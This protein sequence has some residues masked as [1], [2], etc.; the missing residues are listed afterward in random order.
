MSD[1]CQSLTGSNGSPSLAFGIE[2]EKLNTQPP[3][4]VISL[5]KADLSP[6]V[7]ASIAKSSPE[8]RHSVSSASSTESTASGPPEAVV[9]ADDA[10]PTVAAKAESQSS[11][12]RRAR[13]LSR[14]PDILDLSPDGFTVDSILEEYNNAGVRGEKRVSSAF[15][16]TSLLR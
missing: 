8:L 6:T 12:Y 11:L 14:L 1:L 13:R 4:S 15:S 9:I 16:D 5:P 7:K 2:A 10:P 3:P